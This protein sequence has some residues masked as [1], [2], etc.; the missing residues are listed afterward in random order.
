[1]KVYF[2]RFFDFETADGQ[3]LATSFRM[4]DDKEIALAS[5]ESVEPCQFVGRDDELRLCQAAFAIKPDWSGF[6]R[7]M[8]PLH[9]RLE[10]PPGVGK[11][12]IVYEVARRL[13]EKMKIPFYS[14]QG[15]EEMTPEDL[16]I[17]VVPDPERSSDMPLSLRASPLATALH[18]GGL[19][20]F[21][22][23]NRAPE[24]ALT[25]LASV[26]DKRR[27]LYSAMTGITIR[28][29]KSVQGRF[30]F[31]CALNPDQG[32]SGRGGLS[33]YLDE[34]TL[35]AIRVG[36]H[37]RGTLLE[38]LKQNV[39]NDPKHL[40]DFATWY[41]KRVATEISVRQAMALMTFA[42]R[43]VA[44]G[45]SVL[46]TLDGHTEAFLRQNQLK[47]TTAEGAEA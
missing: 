19:F 4:D 16:S 44:R 1:L 5:P 23:I 47:K 11:N 3:K 29:K 38:I 25:P 32:R 39:T 7:A 46:G 27:S 22:E 34:R 20:F 31:C 17:L 43:T 14:I 9:F 13:A 8:T 6:D 40:K 28:T 30:R 45:K 10:G 15:H 36:Y 18:E 24:R 2:A 33:D 26:L 42:I 41:E 21:D 35:P 37:D 12:E